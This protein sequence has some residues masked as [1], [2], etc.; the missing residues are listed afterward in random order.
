M[1]THFVY[2]VLTEPGMVQMYQK[3]SIHNQTNKYAR[4]HAARARVAGPARHTPTLRA[5][6]EG[7]AHST[8]LQA[9][10][11]IHQAASLQSCSGNSQKWKVRYWFECGTPYLPPKLPLPVD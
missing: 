2:M 10:L 1:V 4:S 11:G 5:K 9:L 3:S 7:P 6:P 8:R